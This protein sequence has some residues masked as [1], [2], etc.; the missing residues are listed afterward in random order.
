MTRAA[1]APQLA[2]LGAQSPLPLLSAVAL[3]AAVALARWS[4]LSRTRKA[5]KQLDEHILRD[6]GLER[7][8]AY[9]EARRKFWQG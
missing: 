6:V 2:Y 4:E 3:R 5:L 1:H 7:H 8:A 9:T